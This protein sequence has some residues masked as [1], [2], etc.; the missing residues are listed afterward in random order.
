MHSKI[1][2]SLTLLSSTLLLAMA[3]SPGNGISK[4]TYSCNNPV[5]AKEFLYKYF[6]VGTPGDE[7]DSDICICPAVGSTP[8][9]LIQQGRVYA[10]E[11]LTPSP[12]MPGSPGNGFGLH[13][14]NVSNHVTTGG[15]S[16]AE[17]EAHFSSK[18]GDM[19][20]FDSF[21][22]FNVMF[23]TTGLE[24]YVTALKADSVP[25]YTSTWEYN[26]TTWTSVFIQVPNTQMIIELCQDTTLTT[27]KA[28]HHATP[29]ATTRAMEKVQ[30]MVHPL[31]ET[32]T[33]TSPAIITPLAVNRAVSAKALAALEDFYV[34]GM[35]TKMLEDTVTAEYTRKCFLWSGSSVDVCFYH[36]SDDATKGDF[37]VGDM[38]AMLNTVHQNVLGNSPLCG[39][40]K[41]F[42]NHYA[43]DSMTADTSS[44]VPYIEENNVL[45][46][47]ATSSTLAS[48]YDP[49]GWGIQLD[50]QF[51]SAPSD[52]SSSSQLSAQA[53]VEDRWGSIQK[54]AYGG[55]RKLQNTFNP[56]CTL[57]STC[58]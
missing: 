23:Y 50:M 46:H 26:A 11:T 12:P 1:T 41:W 43:I 24:A 16:T 52:C 38:E 51:S 48:I 18:L 22:D 20:T 31:T 55:S 27:L 9:W 53:D 35:G 44:I 33:A 14:V 21:M 5:A 49:T 32:S 57:S 54:L 42:D 39:N 47:C 40:D 29:R 36:R 7:C 17:V 15:L 58:A 19:S 37:K 8:E 4:S 13:C 6:P 3:Q 30:S 10:L 28:T 56:A 2:T 34:T 45:H 25:M